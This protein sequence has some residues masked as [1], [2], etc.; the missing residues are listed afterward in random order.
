MHCEFVYWG[1]KIIARE[2][3]KLAK[4]HF[5]TAFTK[6]FKK[7]KTHERVLGLESCFMAPKK[8]LL[9]KH[10]VI[11]IDNMGSKGDCS[12]KGSTGKISG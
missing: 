9:I 3:V 5:I 6:N 7:I 10:R 12:K 1:R 8:L 4:D 11:Q 2:G